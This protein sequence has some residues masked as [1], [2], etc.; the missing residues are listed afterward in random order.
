M[1]SHN[2]KGYVFS[3]QNAWKD[4]R[5]IAELSQE[6]GLES[7][8]SDS[9]RKLFQNATKAGFGDLMVSE[10]LRDDIGSM[11]T[12]LLAIDAEFD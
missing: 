11:L 2:H 7:T 12:E 9:P 4:L 1:D 5:Y 3:V 8:L 10:L 6:Y